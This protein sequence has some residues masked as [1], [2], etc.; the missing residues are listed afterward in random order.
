MNRHARTR[1]ILQERALA[2]KRKARLNI[3]AKEWRYIRAYRERGDTH[4]YTIVNFLKC[5]VYTVDWDELHCTCQDA[6][7]SRDTETS[8]FCKHLLYVAFVLGK[9]NDTNQALTTKHRQ[10]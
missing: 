7:F 5:T 3:L 10:G 1:K 4:R 6:H 9:Q 2:V 8:V